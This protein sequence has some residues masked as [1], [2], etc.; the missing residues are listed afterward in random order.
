MRVFTVLGPTQSGKSTLIQALSQLDGR[1]VTF[2]V[3]GVATLHSF[4]YLDEP[5]VGIDVDG[6]A[7][8]MAYAG[9]ALAISDAVVL[10]VPPDPD[11]A[12]LAAPYLRL[13]EEAGIP[14][15]IFVN[16][17]DAPNGRI[18]DIIAA[19][20]SYGRHHITLR[21]VPIRKDGEIVGA[22][23]LIS[24][25]AWKYREG[26]PSVL[27]EI[28]N[29]EISREQEARAD[30]LEEL[31]DY[32]DHMLEQLIEDRQPPN[33]EI[34]DLAAQVLQSH[35]LIPAYLGAAS[36][37]NGLRRLMKALRHEAP[38]IEVAAERAR[39]GTDALA[40]A[41]FA[42][43]KKHIGKLVVV[44]GLGDGIKA[45]DTLGGGTIGSLTAMDAKTQIASLAAGEVGLAVKSDHLAPGGVYD[46]ASQTG[47]PEWANSRPAHHRE[48]V[49]PVH[50][51]DDVRLSNALIRLVEID[52]GLTLQTDEASG[53]ALLGTQGPIHM[54][55]LTDKLTNDFSVKIETLPAKAQFRETITKPVEH[56]YRHRKQSGG[57]GQ[58]ADVTLKIEPQA[59]GEG[60][61]F[62]SEVKG[63]T[64]PRNHIP[65]VANG[66]EDALCEGPNGFPVVDVK[67]T[68]LD[69]KHHSV[70]SSDFAFRTAGKAAVREALAQARPVVLQPI[71]KAE[72]H[73][74]S[75]FVGDLVPT[76]SSLQGQIQGFEAN[77]DAA[78][79]EVF[80]ALI[81]AV[82]QD[83]LHR[84]L[85]SA[86][87]GT[88]WVNL[89]FDHYEETRGTSAAAAQ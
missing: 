56:Q 55:R 77:Q 42:D 68:L 6:G 64:V 12:V 82:A 80:N 25:R 26:E 81:P 62:D 7:D 67:V 13:I 34:Y 29:S 45:H 15:F 51:R 72:I 75:T 66:A 74:P 24:E 70:D 1:P 5:W 89:S 87:R 85:A 4:S 41:G 46:A 49:A 84:A 40:L 53:H 69:G 11:A 30:L 71:L 57:A 17:M 21:Q 54:R 14:C 78:G 63:G 73:L 37:G 2:A 76:I 38:G 18:R 48:V 86:T 9:P 23:D 32:D 19:L 47:L 28:P 35:A 43:V 22:V 88:G 44:R 52:P 60:S 10:C 36:H 27:I 33:D 39:A 3:G 61:L 8:A 20:Q 65:S 79:W 31:S 59:R 16:R 50:D 83:D 58:F